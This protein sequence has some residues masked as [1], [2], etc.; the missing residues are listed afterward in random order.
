MI[1][2]PTSTPAETPSGFAGGRKE[3]KKGGREREG[4]N[5]KGKELRFRS[6]WDGLVTGPALNTSYHIPIL[7]VLLCKIQKEDSET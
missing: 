4:G 6:T 1:P 7:L 5:G 2:G 3:G